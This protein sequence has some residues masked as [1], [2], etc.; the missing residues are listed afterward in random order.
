MINFLDDR[1]SQTYHHFDEKRMGNSHFRNSQ[2]IKFTSHRKID[3][4]HLFEILTN[5]KIVFWNIFLCRTSNWIIPKGY[6]SSLN[7]V[8]SLNINYICNILNCT[9]SYYK[10]IYYI[11]NIN[12]VL[13]FSDFE[14]PAKI[15]VNKG[16]MSISK[17]MVESGRSNGIKLAI[18]N[19][20]NWTIKQI[21][22]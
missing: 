22:N 21:Q 2:K 14:E 16:C 13:I 6:F 3:V 9:F 18:S 17:K 11:F 7:T 1:K 5:A 10:L 20:W 15:R 12:N 19:Y 8:S 4:V